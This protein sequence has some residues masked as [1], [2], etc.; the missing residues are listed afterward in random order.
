[1]ARN[2]PLEHAKV[3]RGTIL[4]PMSPF[5]TYW[6]RSSLQ[7]DAAYVVREDLIFTAC[8]FDQDKHEGD[9]Y[10]EYDEPTPEEIRLMASLALPI[11]P[12][13]GA[14]AQ[15][16]CVT[17]VRLDEHGPLD[18]PQ[19]I[20]K[21]ETVLRRR[22]RADTR[23]ARGAAPLPPSE[24]SHF[25]WPLPLSTQRDLL[26]AID[27]RDH[28]M[29]R[30]L[31]TWMKASMMNMHEAFGEE[32]NYPLW[33]SLDASFAIIQEIIRAQGVANPS[34]TDCQA[35]IHDAFSEANSGLKY[36]EEFYEDRI[37]TMH[38]QNRFGTFTFAPISH[39]DFYAL[40]GALREV[41]RFILLGEV[42]DPQQPF[43]SDE[44]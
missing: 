22:L 7:E 19:V 2:L 33:I 29:I 35:F 3:R 34:A 30:G 42:L 24:Y 4:R 39:C 10:S 44:F 13:R 40:H 12:D 43:D 28:L 20:A 11:G 16:P 15:Y 1:M 38:P 8:H 23:Q 17:S 31:A 18:D 37:R 36:F 41:Y 21:A 26:S 9:Y 5:G 32:A 27:A 25:H 6:S 14:M